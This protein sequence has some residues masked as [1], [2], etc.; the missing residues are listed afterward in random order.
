MLV[1]N[2]KKMI[3]ELQQWMKREN[4]LYMHIYTLWTMENK[5]KHQQ[6]NPSILPSLSTALKYLILQKCL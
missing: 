6:Q 4:K 1:N 3:M 2:M 5:T